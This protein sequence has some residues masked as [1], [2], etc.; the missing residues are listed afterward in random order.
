MHRILIISVLVLVT[1]TSCKNSKDKL[2]KLQIA[3][4]YFTALDE[5]NSSKLKELIADSLI[6]SIPEYDYKV[7]YSKPE[8]VNKWL[9][10]DSVFNPTYKVLEITLEGEIVK[11]KVSKMDSR[12]QFFMQRPFVTYEVL[13]FED[14]KISVIETEYLN[15]DEE[16]W[17]KNRSELLN[18]ISENHP[19]MN[20]F[21][22]DQTEA[23]G[24]K[25][26]KALELY[27]N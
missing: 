20:G 10:W 27:N 21:I 26:L 15:F 11:A 16:T 18:W 3:K 14:D 19:D 8:Y 24:M 4:A 6:T 17:G 22:N 12:I 9:K 7:R 5:S 2:D 1:L 25:F 13:K 23:G